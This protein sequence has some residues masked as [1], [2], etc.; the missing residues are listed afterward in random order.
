MNW[1]KGIIIGMVLFMGFILTLVI[2]LMRQN[3]DMVSDD[4]YKKEL[5][6]NETYD[7][8]QNYENASGKI[9]LQLSA[10]SLFILFPDD[11]KQGS[12]LVEL[13]RPNN[14][15]QD[16]HFTVD[17]SK[18]VMIPVKMLPKGSFDCILTGKRNGKNYEFKQ[19][20]MIH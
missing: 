3:V 17:A 4:Y 11:L 14:Q 18:K 12:V 6:F 2:I 1:G 9:E 8:Q 16:A 5:V 7:A 13:K 19:P 20:I 15:H 10:D